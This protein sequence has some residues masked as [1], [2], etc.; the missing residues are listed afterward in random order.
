MLRRSTGHLFYETQITKAGASMTH[1]EAVP[2][3][4]TGWVSD[5][6]RHHTAALARVAR[7]EGLQAEDALDAVQEAFHTFLLLP[8]ARALIGSEEDSRAL[9]SAVVRNAARNMRRR[10]H[11][12]QPHEPIDEV[13]VLVD[14]AP[15][16]DEMLVSAEQHVQLL[17]CMHTLSE[18]QRHVVTLRMLEEA[19][20]GDVASKLGLEPGHVAV[21][22]HRAKK[23]LQRCMTAE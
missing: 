12:S 9:M 14:S 15:G 10:H 21:L 7:G 20:G 18:V 3:T 8:Q 2:F 13:R 16:V 5:L 23:E 19:S 11:R 1:A 6:A 22:L 4:F 17:G